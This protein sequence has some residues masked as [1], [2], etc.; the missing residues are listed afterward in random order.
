METILLP[1]GDNDPQTKQQP[2]V[3]AVLRID[4][5]SQHSS[6]WLHKSLLEEKCRNYLHFINVRY[7]R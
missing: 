5:W 2:G 6:Y 4:C 7:A 1:L 3:F